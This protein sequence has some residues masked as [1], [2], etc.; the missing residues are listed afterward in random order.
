[1]SELQSNDK[2]SLR[3]KTIHGI[4]HM[5]NLDS[6]LI[7]KI[8]TIE[9]ANNK[10]IT[11]KL[12]ALGMYDLVLTESRTGQDILVMKS[13]ILTIQEDFSTSSA[14]NGARR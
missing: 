9:L 12:K 1:M 5:D 7:G 13:P 3:F 14:N 6:V 10:S 2:M 8:L 4:G 11:G